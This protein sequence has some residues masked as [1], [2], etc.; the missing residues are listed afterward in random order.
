MENYS[1]ESSAS[2][3]ADFEGNFENEEFVEEIPKPRDLV[4]HLCNLQKEKDAVQHLKFFELLRKR[5]VMQIENHL[6][7]QRLT[8]SDE[9]Q[10]IVYLA[11]ELE[12]ESVAEKMICAYVRRQGLQ[13]VRAKQVL[14]DLKFVKALRELPNEDDLDLSVEISLQTKLSEGFMML[15]GQNL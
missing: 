11:T 15:D 4:E 1:F 13:S 12:D 7:E 9:Y 6:K 8:A 5:D 3:T 2:R 14:K 10:M